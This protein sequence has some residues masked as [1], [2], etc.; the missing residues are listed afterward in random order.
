M[1][2]TRVSLTPIINISTINYVKALIQIMTMVSNTGQNDQVR[3]QV[4]ETLNEDE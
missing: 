3:F 2:I 1:A 4:K